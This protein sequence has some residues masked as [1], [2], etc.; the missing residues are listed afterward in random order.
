MYVNSDLEPIAYFIRAYI[1]LFK[2]NLK[3]FLIN[4]A[5]TNEIVADCLYWYVKVEMGD[6]T[7]DNKTNFHLFL[8]ELLAELQSVS[9]IRL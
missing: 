5:K 7:D 6:K 2:L 4:R 1:V 3:T 8:D 9:A